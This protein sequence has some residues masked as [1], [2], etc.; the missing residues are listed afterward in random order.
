[1]NPALADVR[2]SLWSSAVDDAGNRQNRIDSRVEVGTLPTLRPYQSRSSRRTSCRATPM[3][4]SSIEP[5][6]RVVRV[7]TRV[8]SIV[9]MTNEM[10]GTRLAAASSNVSSLVGLGVSGMFRRRNDEAVAREHLHQA[11]RLRADAAVTV[12]KHQQMVLFARRH[13][14]V[15]KS[16][17]SDIRA[18]EYHAS[19]YCR[20]VARLRASSGVHRIP[21]VD[22]KLAVVPR[23]ESTGL[24]VRC[25]TA[26]ELSSSG[27]STEGASTG[28]KRVPCRSWNR[29][30]S[31]A[32]ARERKRESNKNK[33]SHQ[34]LLN[35]APYSRS[36]EGE[37]EPDH[38]AT[39]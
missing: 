7:G 2:S 14:R 10:S 9:S 25:P 29:C 31:A 27:A 35:R 36:T 12:R 23:S 30:C 1:M 8:P 11:D 28:G 4:S 5:K 39:R 37:H 6:E 33:T 34:H 17:T 13:G 38:G 22:E 24:N 15:R 16:A 19:V 3:P 26:N 21:D 20:G 18:L 32:R